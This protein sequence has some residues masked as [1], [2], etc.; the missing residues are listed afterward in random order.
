MRRAGC[1]AAFISLVFAL[2]AAAQ[3]LGQS[4]PYCT[5]NYGGAAAR[6]GPPLRLGIDPGLA[7]SAGASQLPAVPDNP[8]R[9]LAA[10]KSLAVPGRELVVRL[11]RLFWSAGQG[12]IDTFRKRVRMYSRAG[13][14]VELQVRYHPPKGKAGDMPAWVDYVRQIVDTFGPNRR[15]LDMTITNEVNL[16]VSKNTSDGA[17]PGAERALVVGIEA[18]RAE[19]TRRGFRQL[20]FGFTY[21]YRWNPK[22]DAAFF[23]YLRSHGGRRFRRALGFVGLDFYPGTFY[24][25]AMAPGD[26][27]RSELAQAAGVLRSCY[28]PKAGIGRSVPIWITENGIPTG[29]KS[30]AQQAAALRQLVRAASAYSGTFHISDYRWFNL[31]DSTDRGAQVSAPLSF[32][33]DG[34]LLA[35]YKP[36][37]SF[38]VYHRLIGRL[39]ARRR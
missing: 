21:A 37:R 28:L 16:N 32:A 14:D 34:L 5:A 6:Q 11:N 29:T 8:A 10:V 35:N 36:K 17:Y 39:G 22:S 25:P 13:F 19:A 20:R 9:D 38:G 30:Q 23:S 26:T 18:A 27:Y 15:V 2:S 7:G 12:G 1:S 31:R 24:P 4:D 3:P 33:T